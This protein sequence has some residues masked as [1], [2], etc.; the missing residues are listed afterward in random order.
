GGLGGRRLGGGLGRRGLTGGRGLGG[1]GGLLGRGRLRQLLGAAHDILEVLTGAERRN[2][3]PLELDRRTSRWVTCGTSGA[4][5]LLEDTETGDRN[6]L[7]LRDGTHDRVDNGLYCRGSSLFVPV[8]AR[9][10]RL[11][12]LGFVHCP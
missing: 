12:Q 3:R 5:P 2:R 10:E 8:E 1:G 4:N 11:D 6:L 9:R 7:A